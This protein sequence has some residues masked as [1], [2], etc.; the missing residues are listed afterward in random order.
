[1][2]NRKQAKAL[3]DRLIEK[4][5]SNETILEWIINNYLEG[6]QAVEALELFEMEY[7]DNETFK[8]EGFND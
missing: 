7:F 3:L 1:M 8:E 5:I 2:T 6:F 4:G